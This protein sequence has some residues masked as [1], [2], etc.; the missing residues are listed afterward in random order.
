MKCRLLNLLTTLSLLLCVAAVALSVRSYFGGDWL[1]RIERATKLVFVSRSGIIGVER[2]MVL[3]GVDK[4]RFSDDTDWPD[5]NEDVSD[6][7]AGPKWVYSKAPEEPLGVEYAWRDGRTPGVATLTMGLGRN[8]WSAR[9]HYHALPWWPLIAMSAALPA[10]RGAMTARRLWKRAH[11]RRIGRCPY[12]GY[13]LRA[14][15]GRCPECGADASKEM[16]S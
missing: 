1:R 9:V 6:G 14:T 11:L 4:Y 3:S 15:P 5:A 10:A 8:R 12:C 2:W 16:A 13:D 7:A